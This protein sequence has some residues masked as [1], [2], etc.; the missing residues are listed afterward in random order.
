LLAAY[1]QGERA[2]GDTVL[3][4]A[5]RS[6]LRD[7]AR[8]LTFV[9]AGRAFREWHEPRTLAR[10]T[11][12]Y[13][14]PAGLPSDRDTET[15]SLEPRL[16]FEDAALMTTALKLKRAVESPSTGDRLYVEA[17]GVVLM[18]ELTRVN[19]GVR[20]LDTPVRGGLAAWQERAATAYIDANLAEQISLATLAKLV[21]LSP[22]YFCRAFKQSF[23]MPPHRYHMMRRIEAAKPLLAKRTRSVTEIGMAMGYSETSSFTAA[24]RRATGLTPTAYQRGG[25]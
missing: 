25:A 23:G 22:H 18:H 6:T 5:S 2:D 19:R 11:F 21:R 9:P 14:D 12:F 13:I 24:F 16:F 8:K 17:L 15:V 1:E 20:R 10:V 4:G 3:E 7:L